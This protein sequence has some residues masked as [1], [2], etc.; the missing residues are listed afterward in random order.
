MTE[1]IPHRLSEAE[2]TI[3][4]H[5]DLLL[6]HW[7]LETGKRTPGVVEQINFII[8][9]LKYA[10]LPMLVMNTLLQMGLKEAIPAA[11][12]VMSLA[13]FH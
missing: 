4:Q 7:D 2:K 8:S 3:L 13:L 9:V 5:D 12:K 1:G 11:V 10:V 6:G